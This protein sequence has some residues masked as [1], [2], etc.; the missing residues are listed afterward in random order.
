[1]S[2]ELQQLLQLADIRSP[3]P[4]LDATNLPNRIRRT[5]RNQRRLSAC[6]LAILLFLMCSPLFRFGT[7]APDSSIP[8]SAVAIT[9]FDVQ[10]HRRTAALLMQWENRPKVRVDPTDAFLADLAAQ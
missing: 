3:A 7:R 1:M 9:E 5:A 2:D 10:L 6:G 4:A 8:V